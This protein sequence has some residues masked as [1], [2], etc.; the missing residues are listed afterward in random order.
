[1]MRFLLAVVLLLAVGPAIAQQAPDAQTLQKTI[2]IVQAQRNAAHDQ[3]ALAELRAAKLS[4]EV[5]MLKAEIEQLKLR[6]T[7]PAPK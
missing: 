5:E 3:A 1:M 2:A 4:E 6:S 7:Q